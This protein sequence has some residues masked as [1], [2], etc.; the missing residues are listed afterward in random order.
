MFY[1]AATRARSKLYFTYPLTTGY[2][3]VEIRQPS[4]FIDEIP[5]GMVETVRLRRSL[6]SWASS[7]GNRGSYNGGSSTVW[8]DHD[9]PT[10]V[11]DDLGEKMVK[12]SAPG[13]FLRDI[14]EL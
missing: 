7:A 6:P 12:K 5:V 14:D 13:S 2:E 8:N 3:S 9:E 1:V 11:L 10:I 4:C